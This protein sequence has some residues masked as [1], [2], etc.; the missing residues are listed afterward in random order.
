MIDVAA[1][2]GIRVVDQRMAQVASRPVH[3]HCRMCAVFLE[4]SL[5]SANQAQ[6]A[7]G[8]ITAM[9]DPAAEEEILAGDPES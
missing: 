2:R 7:I 9:L 3:F 8:I 1:Q 5:A 6:L 4:F